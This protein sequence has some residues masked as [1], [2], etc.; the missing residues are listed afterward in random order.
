MTKQWI[1][2]TYSLNARGGGKMGFVRDLLSPSKREA[3]ASLC[4]EIEADLVPGGFWKGDKVVARAGQWVLTLDTYTVSTGKTSTTYTR[5]R[6]PYVN[7]DGFRFKIYRKGLFSELGKLLGMQD[8]EVGF[9]DFDDNF[10]IKGNDP[11]KLKE[12]FANPGIRELIELQPQIYLEV[13]DDEG[14]FGS[15]FPEGVD[16]LFFQV[17]GI[18]KDVDRLKALYYLFAEVLEQLYKM[19]SA[20]GE[21][22]D[23]Q[24]R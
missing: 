21:A 17:V 3:W 8:I 6:A 10:I 2:D 4:S 16:E 15:Y 14:W 1:I 7:K 5:M 9:P 19:G 23:V 13:K 24:L 20:G 11:E 12:L 18:I 22:P